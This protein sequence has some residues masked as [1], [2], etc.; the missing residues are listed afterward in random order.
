ML[1]ELQQPPGAGD[2]WDPILVVTPAA[3]Q[4]LN[5]WVDM[6]VPGLQVSRP[7]Y[8]KQVVNGWVD[9]PAAGLQNSL[10]P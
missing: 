2:A 6:P 9:M 1:I 7:S 10:E 3:T 8:R 5:E 4:V